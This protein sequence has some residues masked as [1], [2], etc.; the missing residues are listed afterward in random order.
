MK[1]ILSKKQIAEKMGKSIPTIYRWINRTC[2]MSA[3]DALRM[4]DITGV[5]AAA[6]IFPEKYNNPYINKVNKQL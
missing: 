6:W 5:K 1:K 4:E 2:P 3:E